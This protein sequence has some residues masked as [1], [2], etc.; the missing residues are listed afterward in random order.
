MSSLLQR[1]AGTYATYKF[2]ELLSKKF[3]NWP[4]YESGVLADNGDIL[5][6]ADKMTDEQRGT[7]T[8][9]HRLIRRLKLMLEKLPGGKS[10]VGKIAT[11]YY[12]LR[13]EMIDT[14]NI[15]AKELDEEFYKLLENP[16]TERFH[17]II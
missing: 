6:K 8:Y 9:F 11:A 14:M 2:I 15:T 7:Y 4:A 3:V 5:I 12:L 1:V 17:E 16:L 13:E 10:K